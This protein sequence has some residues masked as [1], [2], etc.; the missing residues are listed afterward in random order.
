VRLTKALPSGFKQCRVIEK[1]DDA[2]RASKGNTLIEK[3][4]CQ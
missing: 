4:T 2:V 3:L 1:T